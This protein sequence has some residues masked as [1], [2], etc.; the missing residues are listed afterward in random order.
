MKMTGKSYYQPGF[1]YQKKKSRKHAIVKLLRT[2]DKGKM[3]K[4]GSEK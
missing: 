4:A 2:K 3:L 1:Y